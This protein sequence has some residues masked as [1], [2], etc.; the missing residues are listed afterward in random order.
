[1]T[2]AKNTS[3]KIH[4]RFFSSILD[5]WTVESIWADTV[6][7]EKGLYKL[8]N[9]P[10]Y[11]PLASDDII[12]AEYDETEQ[13]LTYRKTI[14]HSGNS[15]VQVVLLDTTKNI[16]TI[17]ETFT[18]LACSSEKLNDRYFVMEI[19][20]DKEYKTI[21]QKLTELENA[22]VISY[23]EPCLSENHWYD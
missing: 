5:E 11:A 17:R 20:A 13:S 8:D 4:F 3:V 9:I 7:A 22:G 12:F 23:A 1:M 2:Q 15:T 21:R 6:D 16:N 14:K 18:E 10:Y 19:P